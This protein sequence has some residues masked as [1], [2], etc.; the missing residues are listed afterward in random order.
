MEGHM[1]VPLVVVAQCPN[2]QAEL[3]NLGTVAARLAPFPPG[4]KQVALNVWL[5]DPQLA[6][7][8]LGQLQQTAAALGQSFQVHASP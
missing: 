1:P 7:N 8:F 2:N 6:P 3:Q 5:V 4:V